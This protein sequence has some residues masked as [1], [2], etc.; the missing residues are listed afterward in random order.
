MPPPYRRHVFVC[1]HERDASDPRGSCGQKGSPALLKQL[2]GACKAA[3]LDEVRVNKAGCLDNCELGIS[4]VVYPENVWYGH[5]GPGD[6]DE[7]VR[8][9]MQGGRP[10]ER[11]RV[12]RT[13]PE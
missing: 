3:G 7:L 10:V 9:H 5:V 11:L 4:V 2:K 12:D 6:V 8:E 13:P 1:L